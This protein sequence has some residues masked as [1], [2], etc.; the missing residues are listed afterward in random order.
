MPIAL[1]VESGSV[2]IDQSLVGIC[3]EYVHTEPSPR[4]PQF[5]WI[6]PGAASSCAVKNTIMWWLPGDITDSNRLTPCSVVVGAR[7]Y[8]HFVVSSNGARS[9]SGVCSWKPCS[10]GKSG[11][12]GS[13]SGG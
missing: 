9:I 2:G 1:G 13:A 12:P 5:S 3:D 6:V 10:G 7:K 4:P 8:Q 11:E